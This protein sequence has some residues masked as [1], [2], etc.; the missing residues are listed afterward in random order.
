M[1]QIENTSSCINCDQTISGVFCP[2]C[3]QRR[4]MPR[5]S[6]RQFGHDFMDRVLG[7]E[8]MLPR[9][10]KGLT[11]YPGKVL[12]QY[13][14]GN[15]KLYVNPVSYYFFQFGFY[16]LMLNVLGVDMGEMIQIN[17][18]ENSM[19]EAMGNPEIDQEA[20]EQQ[21]ALQ[22][23]LFKNLQFFALL[24]YPFIALWAMVFFS[25]SKYNFL[26]HIILPFYTYGHLAIVSVIFGLVYKF[27]GYYSMM[28]GLVISIGYFVWVCMK[29]YQPQNKILGIL[30]VLM[31]YVLSYICF[32]IV[33]GLGGFI[34]AIVNQMSN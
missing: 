33:A 1:E 30:K 26:E 24:Q 28:I 4:V 16:L 17:N 25:K 8:G 21:K 32:I 2:H 15:R 20:V 10:W 7:L 22:A 11:L 12:R 14:Q 19:Q 6:I 23:V 29:F 13:I 31:V 3:G 9:T 5:L 34:Y 27:T 18:V